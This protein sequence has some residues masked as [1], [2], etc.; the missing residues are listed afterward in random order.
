MNDIATNVQTIPN[1]DGLWF[2]ILTFVAGA[3]FGKPLWEYLKGQ[4]PWNK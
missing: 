2:P 3:L 1:L 4:F